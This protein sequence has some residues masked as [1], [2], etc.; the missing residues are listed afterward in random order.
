MRLL[1]MIE[2]QLQKGG[3]MELVI[4]QN[5]LPNRGFIFTSD[6]LKNASSGVDFRRVTEDKYHLASQSDIRPPCEL[7]K[8]DIAHVLY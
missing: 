2:D 3:F 8:K 4:I 6:K 1:L 5:Q 7:S